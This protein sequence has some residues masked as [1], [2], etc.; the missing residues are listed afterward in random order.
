MR[1]R[2]PLN[3]GQPVLGLTFWVKADDVGSAASTVLATARQAGASADA[4]P[5]YYDVTL[6][7]STA[8]LMRA[9]DH[10]TDMAD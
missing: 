8:V 1:I 6:V 4:G 10:I 3:E 2:P 7:P 5:E 9:D